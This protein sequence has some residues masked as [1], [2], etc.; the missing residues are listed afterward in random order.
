MVKVFWMSKALLSAPFEFGFCF[1]LPYPVLRHI[2]T[3]SDGSITSGLTWAP[4]GKVDRS[5]TRAQVLGEE[6]S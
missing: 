4:D 3:G 5:E 2:R 6:Q 1:G